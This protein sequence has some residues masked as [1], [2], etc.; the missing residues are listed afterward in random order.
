MKDESGSSGSDCAWIDDVHLPLAL[1]NSAYGWFG[2][3]DSTEGI[4][5]LIVAPQRLSVYPNPGDGRIMVDGVGTG[6]LRVTDL[7]GRELFSVRHTSPA[8]YTLSFLPDGFYLLQVVTAAGRFYQ[9][10]VIQH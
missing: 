5:P 6:E 8:T 4:A 9:P 7:Y 10:L 3:M 2:S 1:W